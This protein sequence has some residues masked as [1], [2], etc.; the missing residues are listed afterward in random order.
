MLWNFRIKFEY[1]KRFYTHTHMRAHAQCFATRNFNFFFFYF[2]TSI[3]IFL[4]LLL[5]LEMTRVSRTVW[6]VT[7]AQLYRDRIFP[8][9][10]CNRCGFRHSLR[11]NCARG[12]S[13]L[14]HHLIVIT[15]HFSFQGFSVSLF[16]CFLNS[17]V[18]NTLRHRINT[19]RDERNIRRGQSR[20][21]R[22]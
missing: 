8:W 17:E 20:Q 15:V 12:F 7:L 9:F 21:S 6:R 16:Y 10:S 3:R 18:R 4:L 1:A 22:R 2:I 19:W 11:S 14:L 13:L 5:S